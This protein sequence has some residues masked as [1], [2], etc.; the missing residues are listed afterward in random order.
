MRLGRVDLPLGFRSPSFRSCFIMQFIMDAAISSGLPILPLAREGHFLIQSLP[1]DNI[2][3]RLESWRGLIVQLMWM[4]EYDTK[5]HYRL[6]KIQ[7]ERLNICNREIQS[8]YTESHLPFTLQTHW[9]LSKLEKSLAVM[10]VA[11]NRFLTV[12]CIHITI[13]PFPLTNQRRGFWLLLT[14]TTSE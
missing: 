6:K 11:I 7:L 1:F 8:V 5:T 9:W 2:L 10:L 4:G 14:L 13:T 3:Y 12:I